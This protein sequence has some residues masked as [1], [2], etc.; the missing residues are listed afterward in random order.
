MEVCPYYRGT[1][2]SFLKATSFTRT[3]R[4]HQVTASSL[5]LLL[6]KA[7]KRYKEGL[8]PEADVVCR[9]T[10]QAGKVCR[11]QDVKEFLKYPNRPCSRTKQCFG[12][13][14]WWCR[15]VDGE[16]ECSSSVDGIGAGDSENHQQ[17]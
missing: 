11:E 7:Y 4:A 6:T 1:A 13:S 17:V 8:E 10:I 16:S 2:D 9:L 5:Y 3:R 15:G 14:R 12:E